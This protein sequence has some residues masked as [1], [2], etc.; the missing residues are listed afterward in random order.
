MSLTKHSES[1]LKDS[2]G[3]FKDDSKDSMGVVMSDSKV[4]SSMK[5]RQVIMFITLKIHPEARNLKDQS[6]VNGNIT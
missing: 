2:M 4:I 1:V 5:L 3:G 6:S